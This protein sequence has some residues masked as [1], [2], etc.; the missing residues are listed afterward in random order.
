M[1][2]QFLAA[3]KL[4]VDIRITAAYVRKTE[5]DN[6]LRLYERISE[7]SAEL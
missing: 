5:A 2:L 7:I 1:D 4:D 6:S 3:T